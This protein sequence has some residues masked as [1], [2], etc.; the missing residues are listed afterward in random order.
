MRRA[1][2][3]TRKCRVELVRAQTNS[4]HRIER[5]KDTPVLRLRNKLLPLADLRAFASEIEDDVFAVLTL[6]GSIASRN[7]PGGTAPAQVRAA[8]TAA[9]ARLDAETRAV[10]TADSRPSDPP[11]STRRKSR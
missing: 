4:E 10:A 5:I 6:E 9:R 3:E 11:S 2:D 1:G 8:S 7:H